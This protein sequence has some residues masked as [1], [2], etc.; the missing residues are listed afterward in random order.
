MECKS[1]SV[2]NNFISVLLAGRN[3]LTVSLASSDDD[4]PI[5]NA[6]KLLNKVCYLSFYRII[7]EGLFQVCLLMA[8]NKAHWLILTSEEKWIFFRLHVGES[9]YVTFSEVEEQSGNTRPFRA[10]LA[11]LLSAFKG[12]EVNSNPDLLAQPLDPIVETTED[13]SDSGPSDTDTSG[14]HRGRGIGTRE[15]PYV[16]R[17]KT[18]GGEADM[19]VASFPSLIDCLLK[20]ILYR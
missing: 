14:N 3:C 15:E 5:G 13:S 19:M 2:L 12:V 11:T 18:R 9:P 8:S 17:S 20:K 10:I 7:V 6:K 16:T 1:P 4:S